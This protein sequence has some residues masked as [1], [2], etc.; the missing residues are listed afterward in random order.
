MAIKRKRATSCSIYLRKAPAL[1]SSC[2]GAKDRS[3]QP[4]LKHSEVVRFP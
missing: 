3:P 2:A 4:V 1:P